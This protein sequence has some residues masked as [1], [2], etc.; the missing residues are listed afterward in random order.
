MFCT[1]F[2]WTILAF[3]I[4]AKVSGSYPQR[5]IDFYILYIAPFLFS[6]ISSIDYWQRYKKYTTKII[7]EGSTDKDMIFKLQKIMKKNAL[8]Y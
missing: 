4:T 6:I 5:D 2:V 7:Y 8:V 3:V 1:T